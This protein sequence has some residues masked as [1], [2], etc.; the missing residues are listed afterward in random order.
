M[1]EKEAAHHS[2]KG[3]T[4][5]KGSFSALEYPHHI[6]SAASDLILRRTANQRTKFELFNLELPPRL[7]RPMVLHSNRGLSIPY[8]HEAFLRSYLFVY[9]SFTAAKNNVRG[10]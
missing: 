1:I 9:P 6:G 2:S 10:G 8:E 5:G 7:S 3:C 4:P